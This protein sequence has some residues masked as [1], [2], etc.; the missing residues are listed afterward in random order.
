MWSILIKM[1]YNI[2]KEECCSN[3]FM[4]VVELV[5]A[6]AYFLV[7]VF[8]TI[9]ASLLTFLATLIWFFQCSVELFKREEQYRKSVALA[10]LSDK[11]GAINDVPSSATSVS[12][13]SK[14][15][16]LFF[17]MVCLSILLMGINVLGHNQE[18][19]FY[20]NFANTAICFYFFAWVEQCLKALREYYNAQARLEI[21][22]SE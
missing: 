22:N 12:T 3:Y 1:G 11:E 14:E 4:C 10:I 15:M 6:S 8:S 20:Y 18:I 13:S 2:P 17:F 21:P 9:N 19:P 16:I 7:S 5:L